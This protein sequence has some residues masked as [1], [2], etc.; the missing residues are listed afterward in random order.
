MCHHPTSQAIKKTI[1]TVQTIHGTL[2]IPMTSIPLS[3]PRA[4]EIPSNTIAVKVAHPFVAT[5]REDE[6]QSE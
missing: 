6:A 1:L 3:P 2:S 5:L 4:P